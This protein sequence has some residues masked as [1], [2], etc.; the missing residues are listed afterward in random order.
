MG[1]IDVD[2]TIEVLEDLKK[3]ETSYGAPR[4]NEFER[5]I[6]EHCIELIRKQPIVDERPKGKWK[7]IIPNFL[8]CTNCGKNICDITTYYELK[9]CPNC[10][11]EMGVEE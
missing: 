5:Q 9:Y 3:W 2:N 10:A 6:I 8:K 1:L 4:Y 7:R 11:A